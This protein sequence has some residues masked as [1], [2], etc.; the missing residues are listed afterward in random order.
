MVTTQPIFKWAEPSETADTT[1]GKGEGQL[2]WGGTILQYSI[3]RGKMSADEREQSYRQ[4]HP[5][6]LEKSRDLGEKV[7]DSF[8]V[9]RK[10]RSAKGV[11]IGNRSAKRSGA[12]ICSEASP[13]GGG[14][15]TRKERGR[16]KRVHEKGGAQIDI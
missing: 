8:L 6:S 12:A 5:I 14:G 13:G 4:I 11:Q 7:R 9:I 16:A 10:E 15:G 1:R 3:G 2:F